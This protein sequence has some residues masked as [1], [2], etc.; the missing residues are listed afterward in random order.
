MSATRPSLSQCVERFASIKDAVEADTEGEDEAVGKELCEIIKQA[1]TL[2]TEE[3]AEELIEFLLKIARSTFNP[4]AAALVLNNLGCVEKRRGNLK[5][6]LHHLKRAAD[7]EGGIVT[8]SPAILV[9]IAAVY[10][11]LQMFAEAAS[12]SN[13]AVIRCQT[14]IQTVVPSVH[15]AALY[16]LAAALEGSGELDHSEAAYKQALEVL[17]QGGI[18]IDHPQYKATLKA[19]E[20]LELRLQNHRGN[21]KRE[22][23][24]KDV[25]PSIIRRAA[26]KSMNQGPSTTRRSLKPLLPKGLR[27]GQ[28]SDPTLEREH[29]P[30]PRSGFEHDVS[31]GLVNLEGNR[32]TVSRAR[33]SQSIQQRALGS[34]YQ[35][36]VRNFHVFPVNSRAANRRYKGIENPTWDLNP[37]PHTPTV[38]R[39][40]GKDPTVDKAVDMAYIPHHLV[41]FVADL[42]YRE[43]TRRTMIITE[44][45]TKINRLRLDRDNAR[46]FIEEDEHRVDL[47]IDEL[48]GRKILNQ[49]FKGKVVFVQH[50]VQVE[51]EERKARHQLHSDLSDYVS[52]FLPL[53]KSLQLQAEEETVRKGIALNQEVAA[54]RDLQILEEAS[55][56][57][58]VSGEESATPK[59]GIAHGL[60][61]WCL[62]GAL[63]PSAALKLADPAYQQSYYVQSR[64]V[65]FGKPHGYGKVNNIVSNKG[66][67]EEKGSLS[68]T[69][70]SESNPVEQF[71]EEDVL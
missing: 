19:Q 16:N 37:L 45:I 54:R 46:C 24:A 5:A 26:D 49:W 64:H 40:L 38:V 51:A 20:Q 53:A 25:L 55:R 47:E 6:A 13:H 31:L 17:S 36:T 44:Y 34:Q 41:P 35:T 28:T 69:T 42:K 9:N 59:A 52:S 14:D 56:V 65:W 62:E 23:W 4:T 63:T 22:E 50:Y 68:P 7:E 58:I 27:K 70:F 29:S 60:A 48:R 21:K 18:P 1:L 15:A 66:G 61:L 33:S 11:S 30:V 67:S 57:R 12:V 71:E 32:M 43:H 2:E 10:S 8:A 3:T 39:S